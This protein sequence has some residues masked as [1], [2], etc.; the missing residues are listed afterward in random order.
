M[1]GLQ[2]KV[3]RPTSISFDQLSMQNDVITTEIDNKNSQEN[4]ADSKTANVVSS[5]LKKY[6]AP[7]E[8]EK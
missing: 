3:A 8:V 5:V 1:R 2:R 4:Q 7:V 6:K